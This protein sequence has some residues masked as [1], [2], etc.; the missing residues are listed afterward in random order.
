MSRISAKVEQIKPSAT[1]AVSMQ[2]MELRAQGKDIISLGAGEPDFDTPEHIREAAITAIRAGKTRYTQV[3]GTPELKAAIARKFREQNGLEF[4]TSQIIASNGAKQSLYNLMVAL[5]NRGDEVIVPAPYWVSYPDM[6]KLADAEPVILSATPE[7]DFK[8]TPRKLQNTLNENT[9]MVILNSPSNPTGKV[10]TAEEYQALGEVL[11]E[12]PKVFIACDDIYEHIYWGEGPYST[13]L[14]SCP[15]LAERTAVINGVSKGYAM[16]GW[17]I[18][19]LAGP[20]DVVKAMR[21]VQ[22]QSTSCPGS[23]SQ[24]AAVAALEGPQ[25]CID[26]MRQSF[27]QRY[28][29]IREALNQIDGVECPE[30]DGAFYAFPSFQGFIDRMDKLRD[31][32]ELAGWLLANAGVATVPGTAFGA[33]GHLRLSFASSMEQLEE[34]IGRI[35]RALDSAL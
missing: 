21:K 22:G 24:A 10:F 17:R 2:A 6:V 35:K 3:D 16:T 20:E 18:G 4:S 15:E 8:I 27:E 25:D 19:Y 5:L 30:C 14:N 32:V 31:D 26:V 7:H 9:R 11:L 12:H 29:Y 28:R 13:L 1:I 23:I 34:A 33:P